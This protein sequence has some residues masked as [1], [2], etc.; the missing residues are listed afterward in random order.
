MGQSWEDIADEVAPVGE[1]SAGLATGSRRGGPLPS[2]A[3]ESNGSLWLPTPQVPRVVACPPCAA[4]ATLDDVLKGLAMQSTLHGTYYHVARVPLDYDA[5]YAALPERLERV[6]AAEKFSVLS[7]APL[8]KLLFLDIETTGLSSD[9]PLFL[10]GALWFDAQRAAR[11]D[12]L[13][14]R[15]FQEERAVLAA[16]HARARGKIIIT[17]NGK[18]FDWPYIEGRSRRA[19]LAYEQPAGHLDV[20]HL[21]RRIWKNKVPNCRLQTL[22]TFICG[23]ARVDDIGS[24]RIPETYYTWLERQSTLGRGAPLLAPIVHHNVL[25]VLTMAELLCF[26]GEKRTWQNL[27]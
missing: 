9:N 25:D 8:S 11:L 13:L 4:D 23:R 17:F 18:R 2:I 27:A 19:G 1:Q 14:A 22:E 10:I 5:S 16:Y 3:H 26:A 15:D 21:A 12:L 6:L 24:S 7:G 20:L